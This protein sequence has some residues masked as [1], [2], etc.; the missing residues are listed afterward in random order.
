MK[1]S[2]KG[3]ELEEEEENEEI[4]VEDGRGEEVEGRAKA[5]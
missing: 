3:E 5:N 1:L 2:R 4:E